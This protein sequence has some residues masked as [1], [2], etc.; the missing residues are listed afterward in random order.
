MTTEQKSLGSVF[1]GR[2]RARKRLAAA[3]FEEGLHS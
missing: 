3:I 1:G 2:R